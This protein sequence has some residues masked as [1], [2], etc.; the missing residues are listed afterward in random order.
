MPVKTRSASKRSVSVKT[1]SSSA[2]KNSS[3]NK[4]SRE[5]LET[6]DRKELKKLCK[7]AGHRLGG[8]RDDL[9]ERILGPFPWETDGKV[10]KKIIDKALA[11]Y[12][13]DEFAS[14]C[15]L[16]GLKRGFISLK[17]GLDVTIFEEKCRFCSGTRSCTLRELLSQPDSGDDFDE[18]S[19][20]GAL[21]CNNEDCGDP[22]AYLTGMCR[23][24]LRQDSG[25]LH[26]HCQDCPGLGQ[27]VGDY[28]DVHCG[29]CDK[30]YYAGGYLTC[31]R[32]NPEDYP[33]E[34]EKFIELLSMVFGPNFRDH[35][36]LR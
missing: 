15:T 22:K 18:G 30:H 36:R 16:R 7:E 1:R 4:R 6:L 26:N 2:K 17:K 12:K 10:T 9:I 14:Y 32:C 3:N 27:C 34:E 31:E 5:E 13:F 33:S 20:S 29:G 19:E 11:Y 21:T 24:N 25:K 28:R 8:K 35:I 23:G